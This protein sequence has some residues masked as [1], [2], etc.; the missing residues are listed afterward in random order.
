MADLDGFADLVWQRIGTKGREQVRQSW[1]LIRD[2]DPELQP[3][4]YACFLWATWS[5]GKGGMPH[6]QPDFWDRV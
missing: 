4:V 5:R 3:K 2:L 6:G 1:T